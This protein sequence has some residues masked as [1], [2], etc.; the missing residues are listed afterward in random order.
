QLVPREHLL[1][2]IT[3][4]SVQFNAARAIGPAVAGLL[5]YTLGPGLAFLLN[6]LSFGAV[7]LALLLVRNR[8]VPPR[9]RPGGGVLRQFGDA[10]AYAR[11]H[12]GILTAMGIARHDALSAVR[13]SLGWST[14][15]DDIDLAL[16]AVPAAV[17]RL[18]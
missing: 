18:R 12:R 1:S 10:I 15:D 8:A 5:L 9:A 7:I 4:N 16:S 11:V 17:E 2:A 13:F 6:G 14:T 3:L